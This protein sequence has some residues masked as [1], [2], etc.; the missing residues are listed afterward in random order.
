MKKGFEQQFSALQSD[1]IDIC[2]ENVEDRAEAIYIYGYY[3]KGRTF[4]NYFYKIHGKLV[5]KHQLNDAVLAGERQYD[6]S[7]GRQRMVLKILTED[8]LKIQKTCEAYGHPMPEEL[9]LICT[10]HTDGP[11][12]YRMKAEY[13]Y[14]KEKD[15]KTGPGDWAEEWFSSLF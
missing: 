14:E 3:N 9:K 12:K 6:V 13:A 10:I 1:M 8:L 4:C 5:K 7:V 15:G 11:K 2:L